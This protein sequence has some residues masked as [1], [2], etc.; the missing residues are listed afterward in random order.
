M[1]AGGY[2]ALA[3]ALNNWGIRTARGGQLASGDDNEH[4]EARLIA[5]PPPSLATGGIAKRRIIL[6]HC[7]IIQG[8]GVA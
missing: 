2:Q 3:D 5:P 7:R 4:P 1:E 6:E 8:A